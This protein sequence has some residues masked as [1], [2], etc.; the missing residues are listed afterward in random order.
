MS[1]E[2]SV[3]KEEKKDFF[4]L[5][6]NKIYQLLDVTSL[7]DYQLTSERLMVMREQRVTSRRAVKRKESQFFEPDSSESA[8]T[9]ESNNEPEVC[10]QII[11]YACDSGGDNIVR[12]KMLLIVEEFYLLSGSSRLESETCLT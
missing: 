5:E 11:A 3:N 2:L 9:K 10:K 6:A 12:R 8:M 4:R 1:Y 7:S